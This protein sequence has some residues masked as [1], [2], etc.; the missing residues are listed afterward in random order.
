MVLNG[1]IHVYGPA[2]AAS[3]NSSGPGKVDGYFQPGT[4]SSSVLIAADLKATSY[5]AGHW[6]EFP[7]DEPTILVQ[8]PFVDNKIP[9]HKVLHSGPC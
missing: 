4:L 9:D 2:V 5:V 1:L 8:T 3:G 7:G 6:T